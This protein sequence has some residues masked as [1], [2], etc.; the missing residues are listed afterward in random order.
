[1]GGPTSAIIIANAVL[2]LVGV[3]KGR[4]HVRSLLPPAE[5]KQ[6]GGGGSEDEKE[7]ES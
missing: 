1:M 3:V 7:G 5:L 2:Q 6:R 4:S